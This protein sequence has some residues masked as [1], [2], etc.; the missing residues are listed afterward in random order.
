MINEKKFIYLILS[1]AIFLHFV[2]I[3]F[4][5]INFEFIFFEASNF[6]QEGFKKEIAEQFFERQANTF[7]FSF[8]IS[9]FSLIFP[10]VEPVHIGKL[11]SLSSFIFIAYAGFNLFEKKINDKKKNFYFTGFFVLFLTLNPLIWVFSYRATPDVISAALAF[12]GFSI[13]YKYPKKNNY[14]YLAVLILGFATTLKPIVGIYLT[15][16]VTLVNF[17]YIKNNFLNCMI[18]GILYSIIPLIYFSITYY[19]FNFFLFSAYYKSVLSINITPSDYFNN[20][21]LYLSFLFIF[22]SPVMMGNI[23]FN[24]KNYFIKR[25]LLNMLVYLIVYYIGSINL[26]SSVEMNFGYFSQYLNNNILSGLLF[27]SAYTVVL[28]IYLEARRN[29]LLKYFLK[30]KLFLVI[31]IYLLIISSSLASQR[32][33]IVILPLFYFLF[34]PY[35]KNDLKFNIFFMLIICIP[36]NI[37]LVANQYLTGSV[38][39]KMIEYVK[40]ND[41]LEKVCPTSISAHAFHEFPKQTRHEIT[42]ALKNIHIL[43]GTGKNDTGVIYSVSSEKFFFLQKKLYLKAMR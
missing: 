7:F 19:N 9:F 13:I 40:K 31:I 20:V 17:T 34:M 37:I 36:I 28:L 1:F 16:G 33:L 41:L 32:Y 25:K 35:I 30:F 24:F 23:I 6:I 43:E 5:P 27:C 14:L 4:Y 21:I 26:V 3:N 18:I 22:S 12:Y 29:Y 8:V 39:K 15:A 10:F 38:S 11:I 2:A 42:C